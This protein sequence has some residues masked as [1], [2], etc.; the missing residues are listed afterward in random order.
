VPCQGV[1][2]RDGQGGAPF[3]W[4]RWTPWPRYSVGHHPSQRDTGMG[5]W[6][7]V[8]NEGALGHVTSPQPG[9]PPAAPSRTSSWRCSGRLRVARIVTGTAII[10]SAEARERLCDGGG[11]PDTWRT[12]ELAPGRGG[13]AWQATTCGL[14]ASS[15]RRTRSVANSPPAAFA[16]DTR[17]RVHARD[18]AER[19]GRSRNARGV[20]RTVPGG[21][22][23][24]RR[25]PASNS[26]IRSSAAA[27]AASAAWR[28]WAS[29][30]RVW[31]MPVK[32]RIS[33]PVR[34]S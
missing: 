6:S 31:A 10:A 26:R 5:P 11:A 15:P 4:P 27:R 18:R 30:A 14:E 16:S 22:R 12:G 28:A 1:S 7:H 34:A 3:A 21:Y 2:L 32:S 8:A 33:S 24:R 9:Q 20:S 23:R 17:A 13:T 19:E 29:A 25:A